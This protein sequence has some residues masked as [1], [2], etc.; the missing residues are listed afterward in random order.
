[1]QLR[2]S[3]IGNLVIGICLCYTIS[4]SQPFKR[5][6]S[7]S[8]NV[9]EGLLQSHV[10]DLA[11]DGNGFIWLSTGSGIQRFDGKRFYQVPISSQLPDDKYVKFFR[12]INGNLWITH[13]RG[14]TEYDSRTHTFK[15]IYQS[16]NFS[17]ESPPIALK[18]DK[19][20]IWCITPNKMLHLNATDLRII[21][22][23]ATDQIS[24][25]IILKLAPSKTKVTSSDDHI[26]LMEGQDLYVFD[27]RYKKFKAWKIEG[28]K[29]SFIAIENYSPDT[30]LVG[31]ESGFEK[32]NTKTGTFTWVCGYARAFDLTKSSNSV[33]LTRVQDRLYIAS[34]GAELFELDLDQH[35]YASNLV[36]LQNQSFLNI[37][38]I[39]SCIPD[40][41][42]NLW[43]IS[44]SDGIKKINY[45]YTGFRYFGT[46]N[47][48][49]NFVK[50]IYA[51]KKSN[52]ILCGTYN[53]GL[54][55]FDSSQKLIRHI[56]NFPGSQP[57][58]TVSGIDSI[59]KQRYL[60]YLMG[61]WDTYILDGKNF[62]LKKIKVDTPPTGK[63]SPFDFYLSL[64]K[65]DQNETLIQTITCLYRAKL[66]NERLRLDLIDT[67]K[68]GAVTA[69]LDRQNRVWSGTTEYYYLFD[70][71]TK[72]KQSFDL[73]GKM[74]SRCF[75][76]DRAGKMWM[77]TEKGLYLLHN[78][79]SINKG[80]HKENGLPDD[81][82]YS[83]RQD[84]NGNIWFSHNKGISCMTLRGTWLHFNKNDGL[85]ENEFNTNTS[86]QTD[87]G[88]FFFGGVN[89]ISSFY[90]EAVSNLT[91][92]PRALISGIKVNDLSWSVD[93]A[94]WNI[95]K[96][97]LPHKNNILTF[98]F[99]ALGQRN[100]D[101]Y[102]YQ[103]QLSGIDAD[104][105]DAGNNSTVR[106]VLPPGEYNFRY[107]AGNSFNKDIE[108][109]GELTILIKPPLWQTW[110]FIGAAFLLLGGL[111]FSIGF[112]VTRQR[113]LR[114][115]KV[116]HMQQEVQQER[117]RISRELHDN[118]GAQLSYISSNIDWVLES[119]VQLSKPEENKRLYSINDTAKN[120]INNLRETIWALKK[121]E[122]C[123]DELSD[124]LKVYVRQQ[125]SLQPT[126]AWHIAENISCNVRFTPTEA[127]NI[128]RICQEAVHNALKHGQANE[129]IIDISSDEKN[130][131]RIVV[132]DNGVGFI[133][134][135]TYNGH[136]GLEHMYH[137][138]VELG[139]K[140]TIESAPGSGTR[141]ILT[142]RNGTNG[143]LA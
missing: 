12:R 97:E 60:L 107:H 2:L 40:S 67:I 69:Y 8:Y 119:P 140:L 79:G 73:P 32:F 89:G 99:T 28:Q 21:D 68:Y 124:K 37:G 55:L 18:E 84:R 41:F 109:Y 77:G 83:L 10:N 128:F 70:L 111:I 46:E 100:P 44:A 29:K 54:L 102:N 80:W 42:H 17:P 93:T 116:L 49:N 139:A 101:Q 127:L 108:N 90:P 76:Q 35:G 24:S 135:P 19:D 105:V 51:D 120:L 110:W 118:I 1:M 74:L 138:A 75:L 98:E 61:G 38:F 113:Y 81:C 88:E 39:T 86:F 11:E 125:M 117:E 57:P 114:K 85:Q 92:S 82:I 94:Y 62:S 50:S 136:F 56:N 7:V 20:G 30:L 95:K 34:I 126:L 63:T 133:Q 66:Q 103:Y 36:N 58:Y 23:I 112:L 71:T 6:N 31:T 132:N 33:H 15:L 64:L 5:L 25:A 53:S 104:W 115:L 142:R 48:K 16:P 45:T 130:N 14:I 3:Y 143:L 123:L 78:D 47:K 129:L 96:L 137:R 27:L 141:V 122:I 87:D 72:R 13:T 4:Y 106:Y 65:T 43:V 131:Y 91:E 134:Q 22:E 9:N 121:E 52:L 59:G 26:Y